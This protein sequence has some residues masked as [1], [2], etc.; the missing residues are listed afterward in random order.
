MARTDIGMSP[1]PVIK[2]MGMGMPDSASLRWKSSPLIPG[3][4][5]SSTRQLGTSSRAFCR[6]SWAEPNSSTSRCTERMSLFSA[7]RMDASSSIT[8][9]TLRE[10]FIGKVCV[11]QS[12]FKNRSLGSSG[13][14]RQ[15]TAMG[16]DNRT[17]DGQSHSNPP[18][19]GGKERL[20]DAVG[21]LRIKSFPGIL[22]LDQ[23]ALR[24]FS[25]RDEKFPPPIG[26]HIHCFN[27]VQDQVQHDLPQLN[28]ITKHCGNVRGQVHSH[29]NP[30]PDK[31]VLGQSQHLPDDGIR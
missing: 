11:W 20:E 28:A 5:T 6:N 15:T 26:N 16:F 7:S 18:R 10:S 17:A 13:P 2:M 22:N 8:N 14:G 21:I 12:E 23:H 3:S 1:C 30:A 29:R 31:L 25:G 9:T 27:G 19:F 24:M 4:L